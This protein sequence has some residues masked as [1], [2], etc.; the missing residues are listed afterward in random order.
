M[1]EFKILCYIT[2]HIVYNYTTWIVKGHHTP[3]AG[4]DHV[5]GIFRHTHE[6]PCFKTGCL[7]GMSKISTVTVIY[8]RSC[9]AGDMILAMYT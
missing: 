7:M 5:K 6:A 4:N 9:L 2:G 1:K 8:S 3:A